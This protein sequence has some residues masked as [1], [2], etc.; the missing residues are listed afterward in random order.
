MKFDPQLT[1]L[2][3]FRIFIKKTPSFFQFLCWKMV[4]FFPKKHWVWNVNFEQVWSL[5]QIINSITMHTSLKK[6]HNLCL[7]YLVGKQSKA[8]VE[9]RPLFQ[10]EA[11]IIKTQY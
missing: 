10:Q 7:V 3:E 5:E 6:N 1:K 2:I 11:I 8:C 9:N 4:N